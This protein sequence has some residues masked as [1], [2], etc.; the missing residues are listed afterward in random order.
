LNEDLRVAL[1]QLRRSDAVVQADGKRCAV[2]F[3]VPAFQAAATLEDSVASIRAAAPPSSEVII[4]DDG[5]FDS[6]PEI[7]DRLGDVVLHQ[8]CQAGAARCRN[9]GARVARGDVLVFVDADVTVSPAAVHG[10]LRHIEDGADAAFG[11]YEPLPPPE[12]RD[13]A[14]TYKNLLH[15]HTHLRAAGQATT[16]WSGFGALRRDA[17]LAVNGFDPAVTT[18]ADVEDVHLGYRLRAAGYDIVLDPTLQVLHHKRYTL[19]GVIVSDV[20]HRAVPWTRAM[21]SL[22]TF[23]ADLNLRR[24]SLVAAPV[25]Y[26]I[27]VAVASSWWW[28]VPGAVVTT[29]L[30]GLWVAL[31]RDF[32]GYAARAWSRRGAMY[33]AGLLYLYYLYGALGT[34]LGAGAYLL[35]PGPIC[36]LNSLRL[37][38]AGDRHADVAV[39]VAVIVQSGEPA[40]ALEALPPLEPWWELIVCATQAVPHLPEGAQFILAPEGADRSQMRHLALL[41]TRGEMFATIDARCVPVPGWLDR[42]RAVAAGNSLIVAG[43]FHHD[44]SGVLARAAQV[45]RYWHWRPERPAAWLVFHPATNA[46]FRTEVARQ[47]GGFRVDGALMLRL[48]GFGARP[49]RFDPAMGVRVVDEPRSLRFV[50][51][52]AGIA[53]LRASA[54]VRYFDI[55]RLHRLGLV[56]ASPLSGLANLVKM[57]LEAIRE[58][59]ADRTFWLALPFIAVGRA[60]ATAGRDLGLLRPKLRGG[61]VPRVVED[62]AALEMESASGWQ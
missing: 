44:R 57:V 29:A 2:S 48:S 16:F 15:H 3:I 37:D 52:A 18:A 35:R 36:V 43:P 19:K 34:V 8:A 39:T 22:R 27:P 61:L 53:R 17:F 21:L 31:H 24:Q 30:I 14:T 55:S 50:P 42:V 20:L 10:L 25:S 6:T 41:A 11:A 47:L 9:D 33:S 28:F 62:I 38:R 56:L 59:S 1:A 26:A 12:L 54:T 58:G 46:A 49:V 23:N 51:A 45:V 13:A 40:R 32:L 4:V 5:S 60:S 7:A